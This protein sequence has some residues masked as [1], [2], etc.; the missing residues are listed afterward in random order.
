MPPS[1]TESVVDDETEAGTAKR[2]RASVEKEA[3]ERAVQA[4]VLGSG[5][6]DAQEAAR[7]DAIERAGGEANYY[8]NPDDFWTA[9][10]GTHP[11]GP[12]SLAMGPQVYVEEQLPDPAVA[13]A[14]GIPPQRIPAHLVIGTIEE[15]L[16]HPKGPEPGEMVRIAVAAHVQAQL[17]ADLEQAVPGAGD[18]VDQAAADDEG[19]DGELS[20]E[21]T[22]EELADSNAAALIALVE[23]NPD[24]ADRIRSIENQR[25]TP[26]VTVLN[27]LDKV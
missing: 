18:V 1:T 8:R 23:S 21:S 5:D 25:H 16:G 6:P 13:L 22:D 11:Q 20:A 24:Q 2:S 9:Q 7:A 15:G 19:H 3:S 17:A 12:T 26:R 4:Q 14:A 27:A 10:Q